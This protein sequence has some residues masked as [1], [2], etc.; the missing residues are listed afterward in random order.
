MKNR[1]LSKNKGCPLFVLPKIYQLPE[2]YTMFARKIFFYRLYF[3]GGGELPPASYAYDCWSCAIITVARSAS[4]ELQWL[5]FTRALSPCFHCNSKGAFTLLISPELSSEQMRWNEMLCDVWAIWTLLHSA[6]ETTVVVDVCRINVLL[7]NAGLIILLGGWRLSPFLLANI[8]R[9]SHIVTNGIIQ[10]NST[11]YQ[12][13]ETS[14]SLVRKR[15][16]RRKHWHRQG[17]PLRGSSSR[18]SSLSC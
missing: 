2:Y 3:F 18:Y 12:S 8:P 13:S 15:R 16:R 9:I 4:I 6:D 10:R 11:V 5:S 17:S 1:I 7:Y 14:S